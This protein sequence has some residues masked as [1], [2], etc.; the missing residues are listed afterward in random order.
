MSIIRVSICSC[1]WERRSGT[2][3]E[4]QSGHGEGGPRFAATLM[5]LSSTCLSSGSAVTK[6]RGGFVCAVNLTFTGV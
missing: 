1:L 5:K 4:Q 3:T 2:N 6:R